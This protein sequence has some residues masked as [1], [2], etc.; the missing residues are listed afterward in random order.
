MKSI[1]A[2]E[3]ML[4]EPVERGVRLVAISLI[5]DARQ[6]GDKLTNLANELR[7]GVTAADDALH[8]FRVA[9]RRVRSWV[10]AFKPWLQDDMSRKRR[11]R[12]SGIAEATRAARDA[13]VHL[14]WLRKERPEL[15]ARQRVGQTWL[16][17]RLVAQR[18]EGA[19]AAFEAA[20]D[21]ATMVP[22]LTRRLE[23]Y[24][25]AVSQPE[26][27][28][29]FGAIFA[30]RLLKESEELRER[31]AAVHRFT[32]VKEAHRARIGTKNLRY[33][34]EPLAKLVGD[35]D[36]I[37]ETLKTLQDS[38]GDLHDVHIFA[39]EL[40][41]ATEKAAGS[42]ARRV[43][44]VVLADDEAEGEAE[45]DRDSADDRVRRARARDPGP[46]LLGLARLL[47]ERGTRAF[48]EIERDWLNDAGAAFFERV[49][50]LAAEIAYRAS[51]GTE[52][53]HKYLLRQL[54]A[55]AADAPSVEIGQGY[56]PGEKLIERIRCV[57]FADGKEKWFRTVK[58]GSGVE[59]IE[60]EEEADAD[61]AR[62][63][64]R[65]TEGRRLRKRRYSIRESDD[66]V[67]EVDEFLD[68]PLVLAEIE[69]PTADTKFEL[70]QWLQDVLDREVT[71][72]PE[73]TN[74]RLAQSHVDAPT[75]TETGDGSPSRSLA[76]R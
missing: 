17:E 63:M 65:L 30:E 1:V 16:S 7:D 67:W 46:G 27:A 20:A 28:E 53:E 52:I 59:R 34:A 61:L 5:D 71:D 42:R 6:A 58:A 4:R 38:L 50:D 8:D 36:A 14:E 66:L 68:R 11:R 9:V 23:F 26:R 10:R 35:G 62:A 55:A 48:A 60:L 76:D 64:W 22:K 43:S 13:A 56:V 44:E 31:L 37:I 69:L 51:R 72:D 19:D 15:T 39:D 47:H 54:P 75:A 2:D 57:R 73:Y 29:R 25:A 40:V 21:F 33:V 12:L 32:D 3:T 45:G 41:A 24:R 18:T 74:A 49:R 70:P